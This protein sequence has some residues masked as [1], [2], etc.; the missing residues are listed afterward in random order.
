MA[1]Q[2]IEHRPAVFGRYTI[3]AVD[4]DGKRRVQGRAVEGGVFDLAG[5]RWV[6]EQEKERCGKVM[7]MLIPSHFQ[8]R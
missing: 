8:R 7:S 6:T 4:I 3:R 1:V 2:Q 5:K